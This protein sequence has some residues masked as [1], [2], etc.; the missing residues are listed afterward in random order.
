MC[1]VVVG[2]GRRMWYYFVGW[3]GGGL[4]FIFLLWV[5]LGVAVVDVGDG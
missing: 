3:M 4:G 2:V 5:L 1:G